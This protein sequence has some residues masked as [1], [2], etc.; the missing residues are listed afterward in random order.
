[1]GAIEKG[2]INPYKFY[3]L[4]KTY[5]I[6]EI[7]EKVGYTVNGLLNWCYRNEVETG[8]IADWEIEEVIK[9][10]TPKE[11][12]Y[13]YNVSLGVVYYRLKKQNINPKIQKGRIRKGIDWEIVEALKNNKSVKE[14]AF[15]YNIKPRVVYYRLE[16]MGISPKMQRGKK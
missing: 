5:T 7:A 4:R 8:R 13:E 1:M 16:K 11:I 9:I 14:I 15:E 3:I 6:S 12:A 2:T 10:K